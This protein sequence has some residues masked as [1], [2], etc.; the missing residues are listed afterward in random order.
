MRCDISKAVD[1][2]YNKIRKMHENDDKSNPSLKVLNVLLK[3]AYYS[4]KNERG[5]YVHGD[6]NIC[7]FCKFEYLHFYC[8]D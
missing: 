5:K 7:H 3:C 1:K 4:L 8:I 2:T 6:C